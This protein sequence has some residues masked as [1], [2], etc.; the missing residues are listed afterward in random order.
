MDTPIGKAP[1]DVPMVRRRA[2]SGKQSPRRQD[3]S[4]ANRRDHQAYWGAFHGTEL[5]LQ[6]RRGIGTVIVGASRQFTASRSIARSLR[7]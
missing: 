1:V 3:R 4:G 2:T 6:R 7:G 5:D